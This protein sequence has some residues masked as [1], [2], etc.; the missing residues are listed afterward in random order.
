MTMAKWRVKE[1]EVTVLSKSGKMDTRLAI[2]QQ[3]AES[4]VV[5]EG[6]SIR[7]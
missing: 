3:E 4:V 7:P 6:G 2:P 1:G 5:Q